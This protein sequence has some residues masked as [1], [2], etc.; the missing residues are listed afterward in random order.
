RDR[1]LGTTE[2]IDTDNPS[3]WATFNAMSEDG[4]YVL[5]ACACGDPIPLEQGTPGSGD[6]V[7]MWLDRQTGA[8]L[9]VGVAPDGT[10]PIDE[11]NGWFTGTIAWGGVSADG[12]T[13]AFVSFATNLVPD[14]T[15]G[16]EDA[17]V[18]RFG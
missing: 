3:T 12:H 13:V 1:L 8:T 17:F 6:S 4:R 7:S 9:E 16:A 14:D 10:P 15:N 11:D 2:M 5:Y 18:Q